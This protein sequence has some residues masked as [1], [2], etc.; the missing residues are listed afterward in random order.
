MKRII[1]SLFIVS[2]SIFA[3]CCHQKDD[4][5]PIVKRIHATIVTQGVERYKQVFIERYRGDDSIIIVNIP[6]YEE[7]PP[8]KT[9]KMLGIRYYRDAHGQ[10]QADPQITDTLVFAT[11]KVPP[12]LRSSIRSKEE[13]LAHYQRLASDFVELQVF[14]VS[15]TPEFSKL[16]SY[17]LG[18]NERPSSIEYIDPNIP[19]N[20]DYPYQTSTIESIKRSIKLEDNWYYIR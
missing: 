4:D 1:F 18:L 6:Y 10:L 8:S 7:H 11:Y 19:I 20:G 16:T 9:R 12:H 2:L 15:N 17:Y 3:S 5:L 13:L 14:R